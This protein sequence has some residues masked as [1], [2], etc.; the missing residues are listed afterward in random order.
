MVKFKRIV[1]AMC[2]CVMVLALS[3]MESR[4]SERTLISVEELDSGL[5]L[6][7]YEEVSDDNARTKSTGA[8]RYC[9]F[10]NELG[11]TV[12]EVRVTIS[13]N[14]ENDDGYAEITSFTYSV[15]YVA[16]G[17]SLGNFDRNVTHGSP[18]VASLEYDIYYGG[19]V[20][21]QDRI[22]V[23]CYNNGTMNWH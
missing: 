22:A 10:K 19:A 13:F 11:N 5:T 15:M 6:Y 7:I 18:S 23:Y 12:C 8:T 20:I 17:Y 3:S 4:A 16:T 9:V 21:E 1:F 14:Y 2:V